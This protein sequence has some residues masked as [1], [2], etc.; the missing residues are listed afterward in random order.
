M[1]HFARLVVQFCMA[2]SDDEMKD[3]DILKDH[4]IQMLDV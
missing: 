1:E 2:I 4:D 3:H